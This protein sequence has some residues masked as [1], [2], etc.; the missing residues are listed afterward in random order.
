M[1]G[2]RSGSQHKFTGVWVVVVRDRVFARSWDDKPTGW[3]RAFQENP[4]GAIQVDGREIPV[5]AKKTHG[6]RLMEEIETAYA[7][8][9]NT[10]GSLQYVK[11]FRLKR[12]RLTTTEFIPL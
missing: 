3:H 11:G 1:I 7:E 10:K 5:R 8:K 2:V 12:R 6:E 9:Y 4:T